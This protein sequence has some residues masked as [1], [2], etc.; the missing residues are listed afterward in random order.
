MVGDI[1][2]CSGSLLDSDV[3]AFEV[4]D[5]IDVLRHVLEKHRRHYGTCDDKDSYDRQ[6]YNYSSIREPTN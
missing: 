2:I 1:V 5:G 3:R 4:I 6:S